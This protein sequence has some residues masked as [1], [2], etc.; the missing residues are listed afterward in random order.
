MASQGSASGVHGGARL[1]AGR[2]RSP[3]FD[4]SIL[5]AAAE[6]LQAR[7]Y[8]AVTVEAIAARAGVSPGSVYRRWPTK[9]ALAAATYLD[10]LG[11]MDP[12]DTGSL[13]TDFSQL[14]EDSYRFYTGKHGRLLLSLL[15]AAGGDEQLLS[16]IRRSTLHRRTTLRRILERAVER[17]EVAPSTDLDLAMDL[18]V[19][20]LWTRL[21]VTGRRIT[22]PMVRELVELTVKALT[23]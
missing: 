8:A 6:L 11:P 4:D 9:A 18:F 22:R 12:V 7:P 19:G 2:P 3:Q 23:S 20:P 5:R 10:V 13:W 15:T 1:G 17:G 21:L 16:A 14:A